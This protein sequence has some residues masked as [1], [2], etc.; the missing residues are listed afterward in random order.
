MHNSVGKIS[1]K[2]RKG[3]KDADFYTFMVK[4]SRMICTRFGW[5]A[6]SKRHKGE[7]FDRMSLMVSAKSRFATKEKASEWAG[8]LTYQHYLLLLKHY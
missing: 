4:F 6:Q 7:S 2:M 1:V 3:L 5:F 8:M